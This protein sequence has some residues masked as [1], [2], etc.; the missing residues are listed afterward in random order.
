MLPVFQPNTHFFFVS[1]STTDNMQSV[2][3]SAVAQKFSNFLSIQNAI[4]VNPNVPTKLPIPVN[5]GETFRDAYL[6]MNCGHTSTG[7]S[8]YAF[9]YLLRVGYSENYHTETLIASSGTRGSYTFSFGVSSDGYI[10]VTSTIR[11]IVYVI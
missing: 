9:L 6:V 4:L 11:T 2:S 8:T 10:T 1:K 3:S 7:S 5:A